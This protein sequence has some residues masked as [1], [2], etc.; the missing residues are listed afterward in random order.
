[1]GCPG[2]HGHGTEELEPYPNGTHG[3][4]LGCGS[5][6][7]PD[8][9]R[10][11]QFEKGEQERILTAALTE[12]LEKTGGTLTEKNVGTFVPFFAERLLARLRR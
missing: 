11:N 3:H 6:Q 9:P 7:F 10:S 8:K 2:C 4:I 5:V 1:M 12:S